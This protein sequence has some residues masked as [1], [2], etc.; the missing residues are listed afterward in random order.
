YRRLVPHRWSAAYN[1][2]GQRD[3]EAAVRI[4]PTS[5][6]DKAGKARQ[7]NFEFRATDAAANPHLTLAAL[8]HAGAQGIEEQLAT[9]AATEE[10]LTLIPKKVLRGRGIVRLPVSLEMALANLEKNATVRA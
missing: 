10:D 8:V 2:L 6:R 4:C 3:R 9:P 7:F 5:V 1:N